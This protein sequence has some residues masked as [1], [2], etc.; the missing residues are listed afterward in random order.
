MS[1]YQ[2]APSYGNFDPRWS[3]SQPVGYDPNMPYPSYDMERPY[4][5]AQDPQTAYGA[6]AGYFPTGDPR[7]LYPQA[8]YLLPQAVPVCIVFVSVSILVI[9]HID[10]ESSTSYVS[11][12]P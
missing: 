11:T 8:S 5:P 10:P 2:Q 7:Y 3:S 4:F 9:L 6:N 12:T 1:G